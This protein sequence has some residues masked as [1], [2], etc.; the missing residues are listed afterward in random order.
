MN[1]NNFSISRANEKDLNK[2]MEIV[3]LCTQNLI[4]K[5]I[6]QWNDSYPNL[7]TFNADVLK[8]IYIF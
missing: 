1:T 5:N 6:F 2:V 8:K 7:N 4:N 3:K